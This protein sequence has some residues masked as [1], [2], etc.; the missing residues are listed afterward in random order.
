MTRGTDDGYQLFRQSHKELHEEFWQLIERR[1]SRLC[2]LWLGDHDS[3]GYAQYSFKHEGTLYTLQ[4]HRYLFYA[5]YDK[6]P[7]AVEHSCENPWCCNMNH[8][9]IAS[10]PAVLC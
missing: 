8:L 7:D 3:E 10:T 5:L 4:A 1:E 2:W 9:T 6:L